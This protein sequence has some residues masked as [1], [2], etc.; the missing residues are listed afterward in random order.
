METLHYP[1]DSGLK[2][3]EKCLLDSPSHQRNDDDCGGDVLDVSMV[4]VAARRRPPL[5]LTPICRSTV[6]PQIN[7][8][9]TWNKLHQ[10]PSLSSRH[11]HLV[12]L[13]HVI[14]FYATRTA[15]CGSVKHQTLRKTMR[16]PLV[17]SFQTK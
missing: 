9:N 1:A 6:M 16:A 15:D 11:H 13:L 4:T 10:N 17:V 14:L 8:R 3:G 12:T 2:W 7:R 5:A